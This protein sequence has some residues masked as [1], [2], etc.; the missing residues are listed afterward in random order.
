M[1]MAAQALQGRSHGAESSR[2]RPE[3]AL[4]LQP[5]WED[6]GAGELTIDYV[7]RHPSWR[8]SLQSHKWLGLR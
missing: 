4:L 8:L 6:P 7:S 2:S 1:A 3:P 5:V